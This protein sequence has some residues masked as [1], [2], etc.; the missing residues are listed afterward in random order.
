MTGAEIRDLYR[1]ACHGA[2]AAPRWAA[3]DALEA[4]AESLGRPL[5]PLLE[6]QGLCLA[7]YFAAR[8]ISRPEK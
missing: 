1:A 2:G 4:Y 7:G 5:G 3:R 6:D 8:P